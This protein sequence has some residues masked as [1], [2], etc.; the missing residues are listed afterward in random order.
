M[1]VN[2]FYKKGTVL[3]AGTS[4]KGVSKSNDNGIPWTTANGSIENKN[5]F[6][7]IADKKYLY[8]GSKKYLD[9]ICSD[10]ITWAHLRVH[11]PPLL[12]RKNSKAMLGMALV[13]YCVGPPGLSVSSDKT[14]K[15]YI[16]PRDNAF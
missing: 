15:F 8:A 7:L 4:A 6:S 12:F 14:K 10:Q 5:V 1:N 13:R 16:V 2:V 9:E 3:Y 11:H